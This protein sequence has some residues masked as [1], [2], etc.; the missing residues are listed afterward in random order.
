MSLW[1][2][3]LAYLRRA[4]APPVN[5]T[6]SGSSPS[7]TDNPAPPAPPDAGGINSGL[8]DDLNLDLVRNIIVEN[9]PP[10]TSDGVKRAKVTGKIT[11]AWTN[12]RMLW[13]DMDP[14]DYPFGRVEPTTNAMPMLFYLCADGVIRGGKYDWW[15]P[16]PAGKCKDLNNVRDGVY[17]H[18][19]PTRGTPMWTMFTSCDGTQRSNTKRV[20]WR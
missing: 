12:G 17:G 9:A 6:D 14:Y 19:M 16:W 7:V 18:Q 4:F 3:F 8:V 2:K 10:A 20:E 13:T 1:K 5:S 15:R 11:A